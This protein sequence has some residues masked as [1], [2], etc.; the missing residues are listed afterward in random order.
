[1]ICTLL[2]SNRHLR[3]LCVSAGLLAAMRGEEEA[4]EETR[5][6]FGGGMSVY[7]NLSLASN[8]S[9]LSSAS[10]ASNTLSML[11]DSLM[12][13][14]SAMSQSSSSGA[15][16]YSS[17]K[18]SASSFSVVGL[19]HNL[20]SRGSGDASDMDSGNDGDFH[21]HETNKQKRLRKKK[22]MKGRKQTR[23]RD[24]FGLKLEAAL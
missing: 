19:E 11:S 5:S 8:L 17:R 12:S 10:G 7:S 23:E 3:V 20:L 1:M 9:H 14:A 21:P 4:A 22:E 6:E 24:V 16:Y 15:G 2:S 18:P 13:Q